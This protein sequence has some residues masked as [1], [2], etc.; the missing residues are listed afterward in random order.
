M[1]LNR[2]VV[3]RAEAVA[4]AAF[5]DFMARA[6]AQAGVVLTSVAGAGKSTFVGRAAGGA[7]GKGMRV[8]VCGPTN[9][10]AFGLVEKIARIN[11]DQLVTFVPAREVAAARAR[12]RDAERHRGA[13]GWP[14]E[15]CRSHRRHLR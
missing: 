6:G 15:Q 2:E 5:A 1:S 4:G 14:C 8:A 12:R 10:Q 3:A 13:P 9:D 7:R 11:P